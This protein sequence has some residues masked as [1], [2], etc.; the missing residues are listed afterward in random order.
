MT[1][2]PLHHALDQADLA[3]TITPG[4]L[5]ETVTHLIVQ[6]V[7][8]KPALGPGDILVQ[9]PL[10]LAKIP[11]ARYDGNTL[12]AFDQSG[13]LEWKGLTTRKARQSFGGNGSLRGRR[14]AM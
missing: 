5:H 4:L 9:L 2:L 8:K 13:P 6:V 12:K 1:Q 10:E 3:V 14:M 7:L 11:T